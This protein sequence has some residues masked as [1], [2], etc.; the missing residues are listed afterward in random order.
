MQFVGVGATMAA[1]RKE[2]KALEER[3]VAEVK[4][5]AHVVQSEFYRNTPVW[6]GETVRNF[7]WGAG[8]RPSGGTKAPLGTPPPLGQPD[9]RNRSANE[10]AATSDMEGVLRFTKLTDLYATN[11][12]NPTKWDLIDNGAAPTPERSR[13]PG[14]VSIL[15]LQSARIKLEHWR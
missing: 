3:A 8:G 13:Y 10:K 5:A 6:S 1:L 4:K 11:L 12:I 7:A 2:A 9:E 14:G 15:S